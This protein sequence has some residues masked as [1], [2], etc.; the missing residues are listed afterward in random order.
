MKKLLVLSCVLT[1][2]TMAMAQQVD[3]S[4]M[5]RML[6]NMVKDR[7]AEIESTHRAAS[8][9]DPMVTALVKA[10]TEEVFA[11]YGAKVI[12]SLDDLYFVVMTVSQM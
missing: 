9:I 4:K 7:Y 3:Y 1:M 6:G 11:R 5:S 12:D 2:G 10:D 8:S